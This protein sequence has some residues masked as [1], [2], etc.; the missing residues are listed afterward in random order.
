MSGDLGNAE[1]QSPDCCPGGLGNEK[2]LEGK[3]GQTDMGVVTSTFNRFSLGLGE[4]TIYC[5]PLA[6]LAHEDL[7]RSLSEIQENTPITPCLC[8]RQ[9]HI[10]YSKSY[11]IILSLIDPDICSSCNI[12]TRSL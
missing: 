9:K 3:N 2:D 1:F 4:M 7:L 8:H 5:A 12:C 11:I 6:L 10:M